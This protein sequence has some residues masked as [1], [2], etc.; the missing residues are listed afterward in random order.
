MVPDL[1]V[2][3]DVDDCTTGEPGAY[4]FKTHN[5]LVFAT[6]KYFKS[7]ACAV[8]LVRTVVSR[9]PIIAMLEPDHNRGGLMKEDIVRLLTRERFP[10]NLAP[11][12]TPATLSWSQHWDIEEELSKLGVEERLLIFFQAAQ[13]I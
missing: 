1:K 11:A 9:I 4:V 6:D 12:G 13:V 2:F 5:V 3:L 10:P 8:E 7:R